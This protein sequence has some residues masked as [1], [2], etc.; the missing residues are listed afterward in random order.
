MA[1]RHNNIEEAVV[2]IPE[3]VN[4]TWVA[5]LGDDQLV[6]AELKLRTAFQKHESAEKIRR[7]SRYA[8]LEGPEPLVNA[9]LQ[10]CM[11]SNEA[12]SRGLVVRKQR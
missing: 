7:G 9:W 4:A 12:R 2:L 8:V 11:V 5:G 1:F 3:R 6:D 10:W